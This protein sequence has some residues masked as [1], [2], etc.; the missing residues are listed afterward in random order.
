MKL[1]NTTCLEMGKGWSSETLRSFRPSEPVA[2]LRFDNDW[3]DS[4]LASLE[5]LYHREASGG[6]IIYD[7]Y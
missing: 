4:R 7:G 3:Y 6:L 1:A 5:R 2:L